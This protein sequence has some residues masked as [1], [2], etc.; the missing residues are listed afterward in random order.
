LKN[1]KT[2]PGNFLSSRAVENWISV[3]LENDISPRDGYA[4]GDED[5]GCEERKRSQYPY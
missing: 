3:C 5:D 2:L 1:D 4:R